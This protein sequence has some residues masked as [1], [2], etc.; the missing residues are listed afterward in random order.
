MRYIYYIYIDFL[1]E[2]FII[3]YELYQSCKQIVFVLELICIF[4]LL[5]VQF[6]LITF[7]FYNIPT[8]YEYQ[9]SNSIKLQ[10]RLVHNQSI[11]KKYTVKTSWYLI[12][13]IK[14][15]TDQPYSRIRR[16]KDHNLS[17]Y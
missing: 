1:K 3:Y 16:F 9:C 17:K 14:R 11:I 2:R 7:F 15:S 10:K 6:F 13:C 4:I 12:K 5:Y 8:L